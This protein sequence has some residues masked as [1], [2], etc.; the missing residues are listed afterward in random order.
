[1]SFVPFLKAKPKLNFKQMKKQKM[2]LAN[3]QGK[4][5]RVEMKKIVAGGNCNKN[6]HFCLVTCPQADGFCVTGSP[7]GANGN[8]WCA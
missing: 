8:C 3:I 7:G 6:S 4:L 5:S 2:S 1:M